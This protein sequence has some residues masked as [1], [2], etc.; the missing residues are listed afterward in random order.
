MF[1]ISRLDG[2]CSHV[3]DKYTRYTYPYLP[4][5]VMW[6]GSRQLFAFSLSAAVIAVGTMGWNLLDW[7]SGLPG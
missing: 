3:V 5:V 6:H 4:V 2:N 1:R 7:G